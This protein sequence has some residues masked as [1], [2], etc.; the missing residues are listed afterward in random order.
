MNKKICSSN[1]LHSFTKPQRGYV[2][3]PNR[4]T[5]RKRPAGAES[6]SASEALWAETA[7]RPDGAASGLSVHSNQRDPQFQ[8]TCGAAWDCFP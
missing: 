5:Q 6:R 8:P 2:H 4:V 3:S 1:E 7:E